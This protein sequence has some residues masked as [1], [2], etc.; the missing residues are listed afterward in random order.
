MKS[1]YRYAKVVSQV[2]RLRKGYE[3][4]NAQSW[5]MDIDRTA[6]L[7]SKMSAS[8]Q[9]RFPFNPTNINWSEYMKDYC[10]GIQRYL[11]PKFTVRT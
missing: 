4:F 7:F 8:D 6:E 9:K 5:V 3:Y 1:A 10:N 2:I 11:K